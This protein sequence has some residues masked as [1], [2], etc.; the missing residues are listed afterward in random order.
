MKSRHS[1]PLTLLQET[2]RPLAFFASEVLWAAA[3]FLP[4]TAVDW[5]RRL[6]ARAPES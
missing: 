1:L 3:P 4:Q 2:Y 6:L 5:V